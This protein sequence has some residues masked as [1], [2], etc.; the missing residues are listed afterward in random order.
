VLKGRMANGR[1]RGRKS[2]KRKRKR[3]RR[4]L[5]ACWDRLC[6]VSVNVN[7]DHYRGRTTRVDEEGEEVA[8][9]AGEGE[10]EDD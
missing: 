3:K 8:E 1:K 9:E 10:A 6:S 5:P 4:M 7:Y 2:W